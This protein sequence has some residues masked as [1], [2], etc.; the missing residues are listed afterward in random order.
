MLASI[1]IHGSSVIAEKCKL[2]LCVP[3]HRCKENSN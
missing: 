3:T 1:D 2:L